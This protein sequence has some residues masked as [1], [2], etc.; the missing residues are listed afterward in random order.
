MA[1][2]SSGNSLRIESRTEN[3]LR[4]RTFVSERA[5]S[6]GFSDAAVHAIAL[7]CDEAC[8]NVIKHS[9][10][11]APDRSL[12]ITVRPR[13][14]EF[15]IIIEHD[16]LMFD[17]DSIKAP[18]MKEYMAHYRKGGLGLHLIRSLMDRV[19]FRQGNGKSEVHLVKFLRG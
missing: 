1:R 8:T 4:V 17:P 10:A 14:G 5:R 7:C 13:P 3:L 11:S 18:D 6:F 16:G 9:Y 15:E 12:L 2:A 19:S